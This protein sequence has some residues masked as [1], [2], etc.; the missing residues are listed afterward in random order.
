MEERVR[1]KRLGLIHFALFIL[2]GIIIGVFTSLITTEAGKDTAKKQMDAASKYVRQQCVRYE[3]LAAK[4][5][6]RSLYDVSDKAFSI[7]DALDYTADAAAL[8][9]QIHL[10]AKANRLSGILVTETNEES[11]AGSVVSFYSKNGE[12]ENM[13][14]SCFETYGGVSQDRI[15]S[16][17]ARLTER[18]SDDEVYYYDYAMVARGDGKGTVLCYKRRLIKDV[19]D[20]G[21]AIATLLKGYVFESNGSIVV[22]DGSVVIA[23]NIEGR[24]GLRVEDCPVVR[25]LRKNNEVN[26]I[27]RVEDD[28]VYYGTRSANK[29]LFIYTYMPDSEVFARRTVILL[30]LLFFYFMTVMVVFAIGQMTLRKRRREQ[31]AK[32]EEY[33]RE[34]EKLTREAIRANEAKTDFLR[35]MSHDIRTPINGIRGMVKIGDYYY[36]DLEVQKDCREKIWNASGYLL[37]LVNDVLDMNKLT[38][39]EPVWKDEYFVMSEL[40]EEI[41]SFMGVQAKAAGISLRFDAE[42]IMH[43]CLYGCS[44]QFK[45][46]LTNLIGNAIKYNKPNGEVVLTCRETDSD[47]N[48]ARFEFKCADTGIGMDEEFLQKMYEPFE[49]EKQSEGNNLEGVGLGLSIVKKLVDRAGWTISA[50]SKKGEGSTFTIGV[51]FKIFEQPKKIADLPEADEKCKLKGYN[52]LVAEDNE[53]NFEIVEFILKVAGANVIPAT[54]GEQAT[55]IFGSSEVGSI[56]AIL[57]DVMMPVKDGLT[58]TREIRTLS[59]ADAENV[60]IIAMTASAFAEDVE[61]ARMAGMNAHIAKPIDGDKLINRIIRLVKKNSGGGGRK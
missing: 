3:E 5:T 21:L 8:G 32:D 53:L 10:L 56:D 30:Y 46:I 42:N 22:T 35:R 48:T 36:D 18:E 1:G 31:Q 12:S 15:K 27:I 13:W 60:P 41:E 24:V 29:G 40:L 51:E 26:A 54:N 4:D 25:E 43:D 57:M 55:E 9:E 23:S 34:R 16:Y 33:R 59:R 17:S 6:A 45:R 19:E 14:K 39:S 20:D 52:I 38:T 11:L 37:D 2:I 28:G 7:R 58:A 50:E 49:R 61:N 44:V 47:D